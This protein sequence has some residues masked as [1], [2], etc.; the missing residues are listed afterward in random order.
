MA[1]KLHEMLAV[2]PSLRT[3]AE[4]TR[5]DLTS[6]FEKKRHHF[7]ERIN[8][9]KSAKDGVPDREESKLDMQSTVGKELDWIAEKLT[10]IIDLGHQIDMANTQAKADVVLEDGATILKDVPTTSLMQLAHRLDEVQKLVHAIPTLDPAKGFRPDPDRGV[11]YFKARIAVRDKTEKVTK[12]LVLYA[13]TEKHPAQVE[14]LITDDIVG[15]VE[16]AEWSGLIHTAEKGLML[17]RVENLI[18]AVKRARSRANDL[19]FDV[20]EH[21]IGQKLL[22]YV[23]KGLS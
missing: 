2:E 16:T 9:F 15:Q 14:K 1:T 4:V 8:T 10:K 17:D 5:T 22:N 23:F 21:K 11:G 7:E 6:T 19:E 3:Q 12:P 18:R 20:R 13:A